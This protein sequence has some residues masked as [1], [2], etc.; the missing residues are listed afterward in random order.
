M[1]T[2]RLALASLLALVGPGCSLLLGIDDLPGAR[3][4]DGSLESS[5]NGDGGC[6]SS[7]TGGCND[8][9]GCI[10]VLA[11][12]R[13]QPVTI[14][15]DTTD[16]FW[17]E[18]NEVA[19]V[20]KSGG[21][22]RAVV[23]TPTNQALAITTD[24]AQ[25]YWTETGGKVGAANAAGQ[26]QPNYWAGG[27]PACA[28][29]QSA[30]FGIALSGDPMQLYVVCADMGS[31]DTWVQLVGPS[32]STSACQPAADA[33]PPPRPTQGIAFAQKANV[34]AFAA[35]D[36]LELFP[37]GQPN[38]P[39][40]H[41]ASTSGARIGGVALDADGGAYFTTQAGVMFSPPIAN[42]PGAVGTTATQGLSAIVLDE[43][44][45]YWVDS[46]S[47]RK[48]SASGQPGAPVVLAAAQSSP[49]SIAVD[50]TSVY[51]STADGRI[52]K[53]TPK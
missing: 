11:S 41:V 12:G 23:P 24:G 1:R 45:L 42:P 39:T 46:D 6:P 48:I 38:A 20:S 53:L 4:D 52:M 37:A 15:L 36:Q 35:G 13:A 10:V 21:T 51:W 25:V 43:G 8:Q 34:V 47:V 44:E 26:A 2:G 29:A 27:G 50:E 16:V 40:Q 30:P 31:G 3:G 7:C 19:A 32:T 18:T 28:G 33:V 14:A 49:S 5:S 22:V 17:T 9:G